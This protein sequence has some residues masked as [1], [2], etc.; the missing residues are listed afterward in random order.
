MLNC[1]SYFAMELIANAM[2]IDIDALVIWTM[3]NAWQLNISI[4]KSVMLHLGK[5]N[6]KHGKTL[7]WACTH[8]NGFIC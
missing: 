2:Q 1:I 6:P 8:Y 4:S 7:S 5:E 3:P